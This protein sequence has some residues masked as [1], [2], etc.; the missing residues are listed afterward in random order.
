MPPP[1]APADGHGGR[2]AAGGD[3][4]GC[5][6]GGG[7]GKEAVGRALRDNANA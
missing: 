6:R 7:A 3:T 5:S 4:S 1:P 2:G